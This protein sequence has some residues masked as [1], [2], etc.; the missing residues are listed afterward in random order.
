[1]VE[2][3]GLIAMSPLVSVPAL[4]QRHVLGRLCVLTLLFLALSANAIAQRGAHTIPRA[5]DQLT[6]EAHDIVHGYIQSVKF[7]PHPQLRNLNTIV[8]S[9]SVKATYKGTPRK[10]LVFRQYVWDLDPWH[11]TTEYG[12]GQEVILLLGPVSEYGLTSP[13]GL[14]QGHF[15]VTID[16]KGQAVAVNG[17]NNSGLFDSVAQRARSRGLQLSPHT[18][19]V[20]GR[21]AAGPVPLKDL[22]EAIRALARIR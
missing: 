14:E 1:V 12:K 6:D 11:A 7:E 20:T 18:L 10:S 13:V 2:F 4:A 16:K 19:A 9:L 15:R 5:L 17:R 22:E 21:N 8:V 3:P